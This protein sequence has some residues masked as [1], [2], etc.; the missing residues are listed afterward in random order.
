M[1]NK[2]L[3]T[4]RVKNVMHSVPN[5]RRIRKFRNTMK[6]TVRGIQTLIGQMPQSATQRIREERARKKKVTI[7]VLL[8]LLVLIAAVVIAIITR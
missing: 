3:T 4:Q 5:E 2:D 1:A 7:I 6:R 8:C